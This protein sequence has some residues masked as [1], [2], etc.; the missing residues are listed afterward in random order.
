VK[1]RT[2][3]VP[4]ATLVIPE[5]RLDFGAAGSFQQHLEQAIAAAGGPAGK[6]GGVIVDCAALDYV[7]S[8][9]LRVFLQAARAAQRAGTTFALCALT[10]AVREVFELSGFSRVIAVHADRNAALAQL[11]PAP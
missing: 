5:G 8:A 10:P 9:G 2:E 7:S 1:V 3:K 4:V 6:A 11:A